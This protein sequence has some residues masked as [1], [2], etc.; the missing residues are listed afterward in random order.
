MGEKEGFANLAREVADVA[1]CAELG[2]RRTLLYV[3]LTLE[4]HDR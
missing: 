1:N 2:A 4:R 3:G